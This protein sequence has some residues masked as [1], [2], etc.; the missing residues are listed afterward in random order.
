VKITR[1]SEEFQV[2]GGPLPEKKEIFSVFVV[3]CLT[4]LTARIFPRRETSFLFGG[5]PLMTF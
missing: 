3:R 4:T 2:F 1:K 5:T